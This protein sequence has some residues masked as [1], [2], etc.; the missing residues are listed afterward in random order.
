[1][2]PKLITSKEVKAYLNIGDDTLYKLLKSRD[3]PA[4]RINE[5]GEYKIIE[6][7]FIEWMQ[8]KCKKIK[9]TGSDF[10]KSAIKFCFKNRFKKIFLNCQ[11]SHFNGHR[12]YKQGTENPRVLGS[13]PS[14]GTITKTDN[15]CNFNIRRLSFTF[16]N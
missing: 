16:C 1:M 7:D 4:F 14:L 8:K 11:T 6:E 13:I 10:E 15:R 5:G 3:F 9:W 2:L 12:V